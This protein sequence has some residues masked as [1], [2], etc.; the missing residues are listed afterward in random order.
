M[1]EFWHNAA[2]GKIIIDGNAVEIGTKGNEIF[3]TEIHQVLHMYYSLIQIIL[4]WGRFSDEIFAEV[5][6]GDATAVCEFTNHVVREI[7]KGGTDAAGVGMTGHKRFCR[8]L[9]YI[10]KS[11]IR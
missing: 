2:V 9:Q 6:A 11:G 7:A 4:G 3:S 1:N 8:M 10:V 5:D